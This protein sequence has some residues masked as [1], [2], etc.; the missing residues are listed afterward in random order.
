MTT[1]QQPLTGRSLQLF[2]SYARADKN[3]VHEVED[4]LETLH[5]AFWID[6]KLDGGEAWWNQ[7]LARIREC[8]AM[9]IAVSPALLESDAATKEREYA[10]QLGKPLLPVL[11]VPV[12]TDLLPPDL[13]PLQLVDYTNAGPLAAFQLAGAIAALPPAPP[14]PN[15][16]P[17]PPAVPLS[18]LN[19]VANRVRAENLS[20][21]DQLALVAVLRVALDRPREHAAALELLQALRK[22]R[23]LYY[24]AWKELEELSRRNWTTRPTGVGFIRPIQEAATPAATPAAPVEGTKPG[25][26]RQPARRDAARAAVAVPPATARPPA[27]WYP[28]PSGRHQVRWFDG[29]WTEYAADGGVQVEDAYFDNGREGQP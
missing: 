17:L 19:G 5:H 2:V 3:V 11:I 22:R 8:D 18:Y 10:R 24:A 15:P 21:E 7:I 6:R 28:D 16:M 27:G 12:L 26:P 1:L 4:G 13:A 25:P 29:E 9:I 23:D 14:P 20:L